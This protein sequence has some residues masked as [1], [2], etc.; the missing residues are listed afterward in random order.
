[1]SC[2]LLS[3]LLG[4]Q[5][6]YK[7]QGARP[8]FSEMAQAWGTVPEWLVVQMLQVTEHRDSQE[9]SVSSTLEGSMYG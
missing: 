3:P 9:Y 6:D 4:Y 2:S 7:I 1:M 8:S 5:I